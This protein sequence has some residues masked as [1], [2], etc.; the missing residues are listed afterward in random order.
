MTF[1]HSE[2]TSYRVKGGRSQQWEEADNQ[3]LIIISIIYQVFFITN[4]NGF[5]TVGAHR[6][7]FYILSVRCCDVFPVVYFI[8]KTSRKGRT[9]FC[10]SPRTANR[11]PVTNLPPAVTLKSQFVPVLLRLLLLKEKL[12]TW[13]F[14]GV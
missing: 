9:C 13:L 8:K 2:V 14:T 6:L 12:K 3:S 10:T 11:N 4:R 7:K 5:L 1:E